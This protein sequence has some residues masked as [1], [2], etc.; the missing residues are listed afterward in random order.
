MS[1]VGNLEDLG[2][3]DILQIVS[4][5]RKSGVL[6]LNWGGVAGKIIFKD[7]QVVQSSSSSD[8][9]TLGQVLIERGAIQPE[10]TAQVDSEVE[11]LPDAIQIKQSLTNGLSISAD[12]IEDAIREKV[13]STA[14]HFF[15]WPEGTFNFE[16]QGIDDELAQLK[17][18][19]KAFVLDVGI[20]PQFLAMEGT[21][22]QDESKRDSSPV[23]PSV[24][25]ASQ[26]MDEQ[27]GPQDE[28]M[29]QTGVDLDA[30]PA[31]EDFGSVS[32]ALEFYDTHPEESSSDTPESAPDETSFHDTD[33][34]DIVKDPS[35]EQSA[36]E[37]QK[38]I[39]SQAGGSEIV[40]V[41]D[42]PMLLE[43]LSHLLSQKG[44]TVHCFGEVRPSLHHI[45]QMVDMGSKPMAIIADLIMPNSTGESTLGG[46][47]LLEKVRKI[48]PSLSIY[49]ISDYENQ[50]AREKSEQL[51][52]RFFFMKPKAS[53][54]DEKMDSP[55]LINFIQV[56]ES[57]LASEPVESV[58]EA[59]VASNGMINLGEELRREFGEEV[60]VPKTE[61]EQVV[62]SRGINMLKTMISELN[63]P[64][65]SGQITLLILRFAA[66]LM[67]RSVIFLVAR[68]Q[69]AGLGQFGMV[70]E[71]RDPQKQVR[72]IRIPLNQPSIFREAIQKRMPLKKKLKNTKWHE[73]L[74]EQL[75]GSEPS[76]VF[77]APII[78]GGKIAAILYGD[79]APDDEK[80]GDTES[81][82]IFL[83]QAGLAMEKALLERRLREMEGE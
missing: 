28:A 10:K 53:Q 63:D 57:A 30:P 37:E 70:M 42:D 75:G 26:S 52:S 69:L 54:L 20:N 49:M 41:D 5:S 32:E 77:V 36:P 82:E 64:A 33:L 4:L 46:L 66:E 71:D 51:G 29:S 59:P 83:A 27:A 23:G 38:D 74:V 7:G 16:L 24:S 43:S 17:A 6:N 76:E 22:L 79:N 58:E 1:L 65:S 68:N 21:R 12:A 18:P 78:A 40:V 60:Q 80:I 19:D 50:P 62:P 35:Q 15:T 14:F 2:L 48:N 8:P 55:E 45:Q 73:Y 25:T 11:R 13:E 3:G 81:L 47:E 34:P 56:L 67:N 31:E 39:F 9:R 44:H 61:I 72:K